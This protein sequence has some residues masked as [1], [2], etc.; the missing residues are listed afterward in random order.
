METLLEFLTALLKNNNKEW[1][2]DN[3]SRYEE[4]RDKML[5]LTEILI[6]EIRKFDPDIPMIS[7]KEC[8]FRI[9]RD[10]RF[11]NDKTPY[12]THFGSFIANGGRKSLRAG[13]YVHIEPGN[14]FLGG[15]IWCPPAEQL[16]AIRFEIVDHADGLKEILNDRDFKNYFSGIEGEKLKTAPKGFD[17][18]FGDVDLLK[19]KS[20]TFGI[21]VSDKQLLNG[22]LVDYSVKVFREL[23]KANR[24]LNA[25]LDKWA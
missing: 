15:G 1:F 4:N 17:K 8:L 14:S 24:F 13:Y 7:P 2:D 6:G 22:D 20:Y 10:V 9:F 3:R 16:K 5:F 12:K 18:D 19:Y 11:S 23:Y 21:P 25:A